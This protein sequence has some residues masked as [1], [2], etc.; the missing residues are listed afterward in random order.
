MSYTMHCLE[1]FGYINVYELHNLFGNILYNRL[2]TVQYP[3]FYVTHH[4]PID[5]QANLPSELVSSCLTVS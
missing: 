2:C 1:L 3:V 5:P 4:D